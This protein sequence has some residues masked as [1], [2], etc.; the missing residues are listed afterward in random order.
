M[1]NLKPTKIFMTKKNFLY[2]ENINFHKKNLKEIKKTFNAFPVK[3][4]SGVKK[5]NEKIK[6]NI[7]II[8]CDP[9]Y[10]YS[11][12]FLKQFKNLKFLA[13]STTSTDFIDL[14]YCNNKKIKLISLEKE[15][16]FLSSISSTAEHTFGLILLIT[17]KYLSSIYSLDKFKF[18]RRPYGG[19]KMLSNMCIGIVG[20]GR[21]GKLVKKIASG[22][23][24]KIITCDIKNKNYKKVLKKIK[25]DSD[26]ISLHIPSKKNINF[27][28][29]K[30]F[31]NLN[32]P[33]FLINTSRGDIVDE[34][35]IIH[36][37]KSNKILGYATDVLKNEFNPNFNIKKNLIFKNRKKY[38]IVITP[39]IG[40]STI[41]AWQLTENRVITKL[42]KYL[43]I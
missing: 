5:L 8:Y 6:K 26:I 4:L 15:Q 13:S 10:F 32:K 24:M 27:F 31:S 36:L 12:N 18:N 25:N 35:F 33:F 11:S 39:H 37:F 23:S 34:R 43:K 7:D 2:F 30:I 21:L 20:Y 14:D 19:Y 22:F 3:S 9:L 41:D 29:K 16:K 1:I 38:N 40:G 28:S 42:K 17:R